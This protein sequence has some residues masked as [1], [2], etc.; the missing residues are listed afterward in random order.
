[1][2]RCAAPFAERRRSELPGPRALAGAFR[3]LERRRRHR[4]AMPLPLIFAP[5]VFL[6]LAAIQPAAITAQ[7]VPAIC[8]GDDAC[9]ACHQDKVNSYRRTAHSL[10]SRPAD[11]DS[12]HGGFGP[13][14][15]ILR[16]VNT[17]L[18]F[19]MTTN[20]AGLFQ[21]AWLRRPPNEI[22]HHTERFGVVVGSGRK[23]QTYLFWKD[24]EL[25]Q[26]PISYWTEVGGW[27][28]S[29]GYPD[30]IAVFNRPV[31]PRCLECHATAFKSLAPPINH[32]DKTTLV[33]GITCE[34][35]HGPGSE[36][37][38][39]YRSR[40][41][42][43]SPT[44]GAILNPAR[45][46]RDRQ[47]DVCALCHAAGSP[48]PSVPSLSFVP[49]DVLDQFIDVPKPAPNAHV[50]VHGGHTQLLQRSRCFRSSA[51]M[52]CSTCHDVH[53]P[54]RDLAS[55]APKCLACHK[56]ESCGKFATLGRKI[57]DQC[58]V[59]HMPLQSTDLIISS[60]NGTKLQPKVRNHQIA[61]YPEVQLQ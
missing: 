2:A 11:R 47:V 53:A 59:C 56:I 13:G 49:G 10:T 14:S 38:A 30:G 51:T 60:A 54:Q 31:T 27:V 3:P 37:V 57:S 17:N 61:I 42:P 39:L 12:V 26:L 8:V 28:N 36:H 23:G 40:T 22:G 58:V 29:P 19:E 46:A 7:S 44:N 32:F 25:F 41:P 34:K 52:T 33:L 5:A 15:N 9:I 21:T 50:D 6:L 45:F 20:E 43:Q 48:R 18:Y 35:C 24:D 55:F 4:S 16:T 1:M